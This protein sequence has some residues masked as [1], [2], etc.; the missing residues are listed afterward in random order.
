MLDNQTVN[1]IESES[2]TE[3]LLSGVHECAEEAILEFVDDLDKEW[4]P[5]V[6]EESHRGSYF[7]P[8]EYN[9][10]RTLLKIL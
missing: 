10:S 3:Y 2:D 6:P 7:T 9:A 8:K 5:F 4:S 1:M